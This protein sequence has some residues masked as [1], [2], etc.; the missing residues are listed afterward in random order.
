MA[1]VCAGALAV[2]VG[3]SW[4]CV[5]SLW[6]LRERPQEC[7]LGPREPAQRARRPGRGGVYQ[8]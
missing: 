3:V 2:W 5:G 1:H 8:I 7:L 4:R 6:G